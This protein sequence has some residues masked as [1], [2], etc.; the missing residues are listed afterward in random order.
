MEQ[1]SVKRMLR[2]EVNKII[3]G[4][5][6]E[7]LK[8]YPM[9]SVDLVVTDPPY[10][11]NFMGKEWDIDVPSVA[12]WNEIFRVL[13]RGAFAFIMSAPRQDVLSKM[14]ENL[15]KVGF[16][17]SFTSIYWAYATGFPKAT[18]VSKTIDKRKGA[19]REVIG[20]GQAGFLEKN[21][22]FGLNNPGY[23][24]Y[25]VTT[26]ST[27]EAKT[28]D[29]SYAGF[30]P[31]PAVEVILVAM[32]PSFKKSTTT[33]AL[34]NKKGVT[35]LDDCRIP[36]KEN[37][38]FGR[39]KEKAPDNNCYGQYEKRIGGEQHQQGRFPANLIVSDNVLDDGKKRKST[40]GTNP[41]PHKSKFGT[42]SETHKPFNYGDTGS[43]SRYFSL[44]A[45]AKTF[46]F[47]IVPKASKSE[48]NKGL[49]EIEPQHMDTTRKDKD[50]IGCN[51]PRNR[52]GTP[53]KNFHPTCKPIKLMAYLVTLGS[54]EKDIVLDPF[55]GSGSTCIAANLLK[56]KY[57]GIDLNK[58]F[59]DIA[60]ARLKAWSI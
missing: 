45:W 16:D 51:N 18:N 4:D 13:K 26:P 3:C 55:A 52:T 36:T 50:A 53:S 42:E 40:G 54:R 14:L 11:Y 44:D 19:E 17:L 21:E 56:R 35:W 22:T 20:K 24:E 46:P 23:G 9:N 5:S 15:K 7:V 47:L 25:D 39:T 43:F 59:C 48:R 41:I 49:E 34:K 6:F 58:E 2:M 29:G 10:G 33:Q 57:I 32:K 30:Q 28:L 8:K 1:N 37:I 60:E 12:T 31:K 38:S 27:E